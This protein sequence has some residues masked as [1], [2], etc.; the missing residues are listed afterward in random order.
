MPEAGIILTQMPWL[1]PCLLGL[2]SLVASFAVASWLVRGFFW[3][4]TTLCVVSATAT[5][6]PSTLLQTVGSY[7]ALIT[8]FGALVISLLLLRERLAGRGVIA[9]LGALRSA[10]V[11]QRRVSAAKQRRLSS[12]LER[13]HAKLETVNQLQHYFELATRNSQITVFYQ[14]TDL[15]YRWIVNPRSVLSPRDVVGL[16]DDELLPESS[17][18]VVIAHKRRAISTG[19]TQ[20]FELEADAGSKRAWLRIDVVPLLEAGQ[21]EAS[22]IVCTAIDITRSKRLDL[23]R[24]DLSKRLAE[25]LQRFNLALRSERIVVFSQDLEL[26]YTWVN[27]DETQVGSVLGRTDSEILPEADQGPIMNLKKEVIAQKAPA[28]AEVGVGQGAERRWYDLHIEPTL[29]PDGEVLGVTGA[30]IDITHRKRNEEQMRL[31]MRELTHRTKN[32]LAVVIAIARQTSQQADSVDEFVPALVSRLRALSAAQ[33]LIVADDWAGVNIADLMHALVSQ[34]GGFPAGR[35]TLTGPTI[36]LSPEAAQ[37]LGL[38]IHEL[39]SNAAQF[40]ALSDANG[41][42]DATWRE[43]EI[44]GKH[45]LTLDWQESGGPVVETPSRNGF[46]MMVIRRNLTRALSA[47]VDLTFATEGLQARITV[48]LDAVSPMVGADQRAMSTVH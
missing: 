26:R 44:D 21:T 35:V 28:S 2:G 1:I 15:R 48:P 11:T 16:T 27:S 34:H 30:S 20:T 38:A 36:R 22:G 9:E 13:E 18:A 41:V 24:T 4:T 14:D 23:M 17:R 43:A 39:A 25:T 46:G 12:L 3:L 32:L 45:V 8:A 31:V 42:V 33:D 5:L 40:G 29:S 7:L 47:D 19:Q 37:N 6:V 10:S